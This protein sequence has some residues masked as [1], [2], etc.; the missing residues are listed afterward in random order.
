MMECEAPTHRMRESISQHPFE[1]HRTTI[2]NSGDFPHLPFPRSPLQV[3]FYRFLYIRF[4]YLMCRIDRKL[5]ETKVLQRCQ[6][7]QSIIYAKCILE[8]ALDILLVLPI[9]RAEDRKGFATEYVMWNWDH[10]GLDELAL[11]T[12]QSEN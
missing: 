11:S 1:Y 3:L 9:I 5:Q 4:H 6:T 2:L 10:D 8:M 12:L 7:S